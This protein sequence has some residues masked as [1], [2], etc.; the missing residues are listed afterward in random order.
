MAVPNDNP[1]REAPED[2]LKRAPLAASFAKQVLDLDVSSG[3]VVAVLGP[4][5]SGKT[6][7]LNLAREGF[8]TGEASVIDFNP[9]MFSGAEQLVDSFFAELS[10]QLRLKAGLQDVADDLADYGEAFANLGWLPLVGPWI[11]RWRG[12]AR[13]LKKLLERRREG[14]SARRQKVIA[15]L[16][17]LGH[18]IVVILDDIDRLSTDEIRD[19]FKLVRLTASFPNVIYVLA[20][21]RA[22]VEKALQDQGVPGRDYLEKILQVA[23]DLP[24]VPQEVLDR[25]VFKALD[26]VLGG[27]AVAIDVDQQAWP[28]IY[29]EIIKPL[30]RN[31]RDVRRLA[32]AAQGTIANLGDGVATADLLA[33]EAIRVFMPDVF[34]QLRRSVDGLCTPSPEMMGGRE[35]DRLK[36]QI[37]A[38]LAE[39]ED[40]RKEVVRNMID[41]LFPFAQ[42]H[43][44][45]THYGGN[46]QKAFLKQRRVAHEAILRLYLEHVAG[47]ELSNFY[48]AEKAWALM[49]DREALDGFLRSLDADRQEDVI[50]A[51]ETYEDDYRREQ[52]VPT[53]IVLENLLEDLPKRPRGFLTMDTHMSVGRVVYRLLRSLEDELA[54]EK[55]SGEILEEL[56]SLSAKLELLTKIGYRENAG[57]KLV[58]EA[59]AARMQK[60]WRDEIRDASV[61]DI[62]AEPNLMS[63]YFEAQ[64][65][66][67]AGEPSVDVP[68]DPRVTHALLKSAET[69]VVSQYMGTRS[70]QRDA[71]LHWDTLVEVCGGE[72]KFEN[73]LQHLRESDVSI[74][75]DLLALAEKYATGWRPE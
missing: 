47:E 41:R 21:D 72:P 54:V 19:V 31:M 2:T 17:K 28:D 38:L 64:R 61:D 71:R 63:I 20:F 62:A 75:G 25:Q 44:G 55:A 65:D 68:D 59:A 66:L 60:E 69:E 45:G 29:I 1:I 70:V 37:E 8:A 16:E 24:V 67:Q 10:S 14:T 33:L 9:W 22:R 74:D 50:R 7:F 30:I 34:S 15:A 52:V 56:K 58:S 26:E 49:T 51:L 73:R 12:G 6:S 4:W 43:T 40:G 18:P 53:S 46:S 27:A 57:H 36:S 48:D 35:P 23:I 32:A 13:L 5:G 3:F 11:E 42:R 39:P